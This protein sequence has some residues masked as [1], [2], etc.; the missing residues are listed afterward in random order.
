MLASGRTRCEIFSYH[1]SI[2]NS[3]YGDLAGRV[4][5]AGALL[6]QT[7]APPEDLATHTRLLLTLPLIL[8][9][10]LGQRNKEFSRQKLTTCLTSPQDLLS[11]TKTH[12]FFFSFL[13]I[14]RI[15]LD[16][17]TECRKL[18]IFSCPRWDQG[19][20]E[21]KGKSRVSDRQEPSQGI[22]CQNNP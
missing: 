1:F 18:S 5:K 13:Q 8:K 17:Q 20:A 14:N 19:R 21:I 3:N 12:L 11:F 2:C 16:G 4:L 6:P 7:V 22:G 9:A 10:L 15:T